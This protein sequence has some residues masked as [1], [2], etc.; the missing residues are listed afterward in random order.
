MPRRSTATK[1]FVPPYP[2]RPDRPRA[3][4]PTLLS[5]QRNPIKLWCEADFEGPVSVGRT[6]FGLRGAAHDP[7]AVRRIFLDNAANYREDDLQLRI[8]RPGLGNGLLTAE[9]EHRRVQRTLG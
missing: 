6:V 1:L 5:L 4:L 7:A 3:S 9:G 8:L 2:P